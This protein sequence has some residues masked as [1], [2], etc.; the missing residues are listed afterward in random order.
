M[1]KITYSKEQGD[2]SIILVT[3]VVDNDSFVNLIQDSSVHI[4]F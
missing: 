4:V 1:R 3:K 2:H